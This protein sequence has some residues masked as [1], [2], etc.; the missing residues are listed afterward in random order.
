MADEAVCIGPAQAKL[1]YLNEDVILDAIKK[2]GA[3]AVHPGYGFLSENTKFAKKLVRYSFSSINKY[4]YSFRLIIMLNLS[5]HQV[6]QLKLW[7]IKFK[8]KSL[9]EKRMSQ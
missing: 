3:E 4:L 9:L 5:V 2:T 6:N 8:V 1:S 7:V